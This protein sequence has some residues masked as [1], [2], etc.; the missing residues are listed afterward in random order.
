M[1]QLGLYDH[2]DAGDITQLSGL[3]THDG[4]TEEWGRAFSALASELRVHPPRP[5]NPTDAF[6][7][8][9]ACTADPQARAV[10]RERALGSFRS[11]GPAP[12]P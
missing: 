10:A 2:P 5:R 6:L 7:D 11:P 9:E 12:Q 4:R 3:L 8:W 1:A